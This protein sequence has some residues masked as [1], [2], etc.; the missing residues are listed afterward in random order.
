MNP[1]EYLNAVAAELRGLTSYERAAVR[2]ELEGHIEDHAEALRA[3]GYPEDEAEARAAERMGDPAETGRGIA[4]LYHPA[5]LWA[6]R[7]AGALI[8]VMALELF[9]GFGGL[10][11]VAGSVYAR[12]CK[13]D[14][15]HVTALDE[16]MEIGN[17]V[18]R[19]Y[20]INRYSDGQ[21]DGVELWLCAYDRVP[22]GVVAQNIWGWSAV[23]ANGEER[24]RYADGGGWS[25]ARVTYCHIKVPLEPG[26]KTVALRFERFG[27]AVERAVDL[28]E[29][30]P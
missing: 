4:R 30:L 14:D 7:V 21:E 18:V 12:F 26:D 17:D 13:P 1:E 15:A 3:H 2:R 22:T 8:A 5:W 11:G 23:T 27:E 24:V 9:L 28:T 10:G 29:V 6:E 20:G 25:N 19:L 16:R